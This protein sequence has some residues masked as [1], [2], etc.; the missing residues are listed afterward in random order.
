[1]NNREYLLASLGEEAG[2][3][4]QAVGK[5]LRFGLLDSNI[6]DPDSGTNWVKLRQEVHDLVAVY[7]MLCEEFGEVP[8]LD[9]E[10][11]E[12]KKEK[13]KKWQEYARS[14]GTLT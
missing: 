9:R 14:V 13:V 10:L 3:V 8:E 2:E 12:K 7:A 6:K 1:M 4:T 11:L 5:A